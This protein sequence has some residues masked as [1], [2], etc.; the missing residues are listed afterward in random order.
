MCAKGHATTGDKY[1][2]LDDKC[3]KAD[4]GTTSVWLWFS[5]GQYYDSHPTLSCYLSYKD[6]TCGGCPTSFYDTFEQW[7]YEGMQD[8]RKTWSICHDVR[9]KKGGKSY[10]VVKVSEEIS[11]SDPTAWKCMTRVRRATV[12]PQNS[13]LTFQGR[14]KDYKEKLK[15]KGTC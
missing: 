13:K 12:Y 15:K 10:A 6:D 7:K 1:N 9:G 14:C 11:I 2:Y 3:R 8:D 5:Q 4:P